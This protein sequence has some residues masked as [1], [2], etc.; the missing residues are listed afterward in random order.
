MKRTLLW[1]RDDLRLADNPALV[2]AAARGEIIPVYIRDTTNPKPTGAAS[3]WWLHGSLRDIAN[4]LR[5]LVLRSGDP[6]EIIPTL[7]AET[8]ATAVVWNRTY[9]PHAI[10]RDTDLKSLLQGMGIEV[11]S[12]NARLLTE[13]WDIRTGEGKP[14]TVFTPFWKGCLKRLEAH[15][16]P[17]P[18]PV[19]KVQVAP[20]PASDNLADWNLLPTNPN[21]AKDWKDMWDA[22]E[23]GAHTRLATFLKDELYGYANGRDKPDK[24]HVSR[25]SPWLANGNIGPRQLWHATQAAIQYHPALVGD[26]AKFLAEVGW[27]EFSYHLLYHHPRLPTH[28]FKPAFD[29]YPWETNPAHLKAWQRGQTG[30]PFVDAGMREL[31]ATGTMHNRVRM[32]VASFLIKHLRLDWRHGERWFWDCLLD[33]DLASN[34]ASWQWVAGSGAD[35][36]PYF[37][38]FNPFVQGQKF[39]PDGTYTRRWVPELAKLPTAYLQTP[40]EAPLLV[41]ASAGVTL[42]TTYPHPLVNH[43]NAR[44]KAMEGYQK[45]KEKNAP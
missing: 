21:W 26:A 11:H 39:D 37:R 12:A 3:N 13:P 7:V 34:S 42:G 17:A 41:L 40:W 33:A 38:I 30:Y 32:V 8:G 31:W 1:F 43:E 16:I 36:S 5:G 24:S 35:A 23:A 14:Y 22:T 25:L 9:T 15:P 4:R 18:L 29:A 45:V 44:T 19:P 10:A 28:N 27:R 20:L 2:W 6:R